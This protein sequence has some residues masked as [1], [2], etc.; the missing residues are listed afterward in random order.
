MI[1]KCILLTIFG[2]I[3]ALFIIELLLNIGGYFV[4]VIHENKEIT[5]NLNRDS[6]EF[7]NILC[8]GDS[9]TFGVGAKPGFS[10]P[11]QLQRMIDKENIKY[12]V[13]NLGIPGTNS[14]TVLLNI[15][16]WIKMYKPKVVILMIG[17]N[18]NLNLQNSNYYIFMKDKK[19]F[20][21]WINRI[22]FNL[23]TYK[24]FNL[25]IRSFSRKNVNFIKVESYPEDIKNKIR[26]V[27]EYYFHIKRNFVKSKEIL[28]EI[29]E[30]DKDNYDAYL[31]LG[32]IALDS[33]EFAL[34]EKNL[35]RAKEINPYRSEAYEQ[36]FRLYCGLGDRESADNELKEML[37]LFSEQEDLKKLKIFGI[38]LPQDIVLW[39]KELRYNLCK[40]IESLK[41]N[42]IYIILINYPKPRPFHTEIISKIVDEYGLT[43]I[44]NGIYLDKNI[45]K[46]YFT[47]DAHPNELGYSII[48]KNVFNVL[49]EINK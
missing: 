3:L 28:N 35:K 33:D 31:M 5:K 18:D 23:K 39:S 25:L 49:K 12:K 11:E 34:A 45:D 42:K 9:H 24:L 1:L 27:R 48:A 7:L 17:C 14:S 15:P 13:Y 36:L 21:Y 8:I 46:E 4:K 19:S 30:I 38:P 40:I 16:K 41:S 43:Y 32:W 2:I 26:L 37:N 20:F 47:S 44:D 22:L 6:S 10:Y 29:L